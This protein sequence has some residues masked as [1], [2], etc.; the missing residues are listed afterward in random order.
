MYQVSLAAKTQRPSKNNTTTLNGSRVNCTC[1]FPYISAQVISG[2]RSNCWEHL[3]MCPCGSGHSESKYRPELRWVS[4]H[5][6]ARQTRLW[7]SMPW[8]R[9]QLLSISPRV[10]LR[11]LFPVPTV[12]TC[13][14]SFFFSVCLSF[15]SPSFCRFH[16]PFLSFRSSFFILLFSLLCCSFS[17]V[18]FLS[19]FLSFLPSFPFLKKASSSWPMLQCSSNRG[20]EQMLRCDE[21][22]ASGCSCF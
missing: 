20:W 14:H 12:N 13:S 9:L 6:Q 5:V 1:L 4:A 2:T 22:H 15:V 8:H 18:I 16:F 3:F 21:M 7:Q 10:R 11:D 19:F 17:C